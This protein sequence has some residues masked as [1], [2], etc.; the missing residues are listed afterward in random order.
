MNT[1]IIN[2]KEFEKINETTKQ[3]AALVSDISRTTKKDIFGIYGRPSVTKIKIY[4]SW[5]NWYKGISDNDN[6]FGC[7]RGGSSTFSIGGIIE[8]ANRT[9]YLYITKDHNR[10]VVIKEV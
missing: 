1:I 5:K 7:M 6:N 10:A 3:A 9:I 8:E 4:Q 2:G